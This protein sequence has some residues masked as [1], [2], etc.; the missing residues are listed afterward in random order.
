MEKRIALLNNGIVFNIVIGNSAEEISSLF[1][2]DAVEITESTDQAHIGYAFLD[3]V[4]EQPPAQEYE[5]VFPT[6]NQESE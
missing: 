4:F 1:N 6:P 2:C 3:G 5:V